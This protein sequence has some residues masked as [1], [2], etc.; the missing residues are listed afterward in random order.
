MFDLESWFDSGSSFDPKDAVFK[1]VGKVPGN[2]VNLEEFILAECHSDLGTAF[3]QFWIAFIADMYKEDDLNKGIRKV[4]KILSTIELHLYTAL[5][6]ILKARGYFQGGVNHTCTVTDANLSLL[7][8]A[9]GIKRLTV[10]D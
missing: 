7:M 8:F 4:G 3:G 1:A 10:H 5:D 9:I 6:C 2:K